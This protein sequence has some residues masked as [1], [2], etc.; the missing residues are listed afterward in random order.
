[1]PIYKQES[2][3]YWYIDIIGPSG[4]RIRRSSR[5]ANKEEAQELHDR[6]KSDLWRVRQL[7]DRQKHT[8]EE[9]ALRWLQENS[10]KRSLENDKLFLRHFVPIFRGQYLN[11]IKRDA[12]LTS[13][14][15]L[16]VS[17]ATK[18]RHLAL[19]RAI[20]RKAEREWD[21][22]EKA[23]AIKLL[24][25]PK[26]RVRWITPEQAATLLRELPEHQRAVVTFALAT[27]LRQSNVLNLR[28]LDID[29]PR[30][31]AW[32]HHDESKTGKAMTVPI[33]DTAVAIL[34]EQFGRQPEFVF[35]YRGKNIAEANTKAW[36]AALIRAGISDFRWHDLRHCWASWLV[37][38]G[39]P[40]IALQE[41][42]GW[43]SE[44]MVKRYAHLSADHLLGHSKL[45]DD[46]LLSYPQKTRG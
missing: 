32:V 2:S 4:E 13:V 39:T 24:P 5:T 15:K 35:T 43:S 8:F 14:S 10:H 7:G 11:E 37:Q 33:N 34:R 22:L 25:E 29:L 3:Q 20:L 18:N 19:I 42:G 16:H 27:G 45:L 12:I 41:M 36:R 9:A 28:W 23:P 1:M 40:L 30:R 26:R 31:V 38:G 6:L 44:Q 17:N 46:K 21:W